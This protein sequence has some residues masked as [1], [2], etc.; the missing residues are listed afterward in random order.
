MP[1]YTAGAFRDPYTQADLPASASAVRRAT[2]DQAVSDL[3]APSLFR[4][5]ELNI[6]EKRGALYGYRQ[7]DPRQAE[8]FMAANGLAGQFKFEDRAYN[9]LE[10]SI[11]ATRKTA[12]LKRQAIL[13]RAENSGS[14]ALGR[15]GITIATPFLDPLTVGTAFVPV[16]GPSKYAA[17]LEKAGASA[18]ARA[19]VRAQVG[20]L[21]GAVGAAAVEPIIYGAH[22]QEQADYTLA[23]SLLNIGI[24]T[25]FGGGLHT[26]GGAVADIGSRGRRA[27]AEARVAAWRQFLDENEPAP[28][29]PVELALRRATVAEVDASVDALYRARRSDIE[30]AMV[31][32]LSRV[33]EATLREDYKALREQAGRQ[34]AAADPEGAAATDAR[35]ADVDAR[36]VANERAKLAD[37]ELKRLESAWA[38]AASTKDRATLMQGEDGPLWRSIEAAEN[39]E[40]LTAVEARIKELEMQRPVVEARLSAAEKQRPVGLLAET[41]EADRQT[42]MR[43]ANREL[44][45]IDAE[46]LRMRPE[47]ER[48]GELAKATPMISVYRASPQEREAA[49]RSAVAQAVTGEAIEVRPIFDRATMPDSAR[50]LADPD[51]RPLADP[52]AVERADTMQAAG[53]SSDLAAVRQEFDEVSAQVKAMLDELDLGEDGKELADS[54]RAELAESREAVAEVKDLARV[55]S[56]LATCAMRHAP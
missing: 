4:S 16:I 21:E 25:A 27:R 22:A 7:Y 1:I 37:G 6:A 42:A 34:D 49:L 50:R 18:L 17:M 33:D 23:D 56:L 52:A 53:E 54:I 30:E 43:D 14:T 28:F 10:L 44:R 26:L 8:D 40:T 55:A 29:T 2:F 36:L 41:L 24:G 38:R 11:L 12:E 5:L 48:L 20:A 13:S 47:A 31:G 45:G 32:R 15:F 3:L 46:L 9:Q 39:A 19:G 35:I 51:Q